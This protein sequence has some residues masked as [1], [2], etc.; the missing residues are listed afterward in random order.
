[1]AGARADPAAELDRQIAGRARPVRGFAES[2]GLG[3]EVFTTRI[4][5]IYGVSAIL[6]AAG[7]P[8]LPRL[9]EGV[10]GRAAME[11]QLKAILSKST[12]AADIATAEKEGF[13]TGR[14]AVNP[15]SGDLVPIWVANFVLAEYGT[16]AVMCVPAHDQRD[17]EF[18]EKYHLPVKIVIQ[19]RA[20]TGL[21]RRPIE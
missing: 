13:F 6:I 20:G 18:A 12:R 16:G 19:P 3:L 17:Y 4:D 10:P 14:F 9:L 15:F 8:Q 2:D 7:H 11:A 5:T 21:A 1:M